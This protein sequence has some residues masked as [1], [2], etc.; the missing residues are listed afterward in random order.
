MR[1]LILERLAAAAA[2]ATRG[3]NDLNPASAPVSGPLTPAA[4]LVPLLDRP[5]GLSVL[6]TTR[7]PHLSKHAGQIS[8]P[9]G[10][11]EAGDADAVAAALR[12][13]EEEIGL[14]RRYVEIVGQLD[15]YVTGTGFAVTPVVGLVALG[16]QLNPDPHEVAEVFE[17]PLAFL[18]D[19]RNH[20]RHSGVRNGQE[21][22][23][24]AIPYDGHYIWG[25]TAGM[26]V[27]LHAKVCGGA[28]TVGA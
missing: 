21:R 26:L 18:L 27:N 7:T 25:A 15:T 8:F 14:E 23:W 17:V 24:F 5:D 19:P 3:D 28:Q 20:Q 16:F 6:F 13:T 12:E 2:A 9:G 10:R 11:I 4:V 1:E 22:H